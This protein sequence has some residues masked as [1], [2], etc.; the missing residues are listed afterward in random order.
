MSIKGSAR[1][2]GRM[3]SSGPWQARPGYQVEQMRAGLQ[4]TVGKPQVVTKTING[5]VYEPLEHMID[6]VPGVPG[7]CHPADGR[8]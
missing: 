3:G 7:C 4:L 6:D 8:T 2:V 1:S 5:K